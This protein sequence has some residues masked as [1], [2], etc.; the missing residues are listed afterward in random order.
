LL[1]YQRSIPLPNR[2]EE[3]TTEIAY[4]FRETSEKEAR[5]ALVLGH[6]LILPLALQNE[7]FELRL[8]DQI[9]ARVDAF[10]AIRR[11][12]SGHR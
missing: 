8:D 9:Q 1:A 2:L 3:Y 12:S 4:S 10:L 5:L 11:D 6:N 7:H